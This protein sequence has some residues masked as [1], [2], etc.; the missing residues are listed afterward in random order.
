[1]YNKMS[2]TINPNI[3]RILSE[4]SYDDATKELVRQLLNLELLYVNRS[5]YDVTNE[6]LRLVDDVDTEKPA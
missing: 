1:M 5:N 2:K 6:I 3:D 4:S